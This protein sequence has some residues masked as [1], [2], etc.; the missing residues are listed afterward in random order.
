MDEFETDNKA[1]AASPRWIGARSIPLAHQLNE[2]CVELVCELAATSSTKNSRDSSCRTATSGG[3]LKPKLAYVS[4]HS[5]LSSSIVA[6][7]TPNR[8]SGPAKDT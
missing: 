4:R 8:G 3:F 2:Q 1:S 6:S 7:G 5:R